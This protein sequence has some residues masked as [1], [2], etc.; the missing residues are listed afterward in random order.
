MDFEWDE[1]KRDSNYAKHQIDFVD[2]ASIWNRPLID[3]AYVRQ[4]GNEERVVALGTIG[5]AQ[6]II[7]VVYTIRGSTKRIISAR[8]ARRHERQSYTDKFGS[9]R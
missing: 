1:R 5:D 7:A 8:R 9:G 6:F 4:V 2:A 3:P